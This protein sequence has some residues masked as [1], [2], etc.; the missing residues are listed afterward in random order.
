M[1]VVS[2][3]SWDWLVLERSRPTATS[4]RMA[5]TG[6]A[7]RARTARTMGSSIYGELPALDHREMSRTSLPN[8]TDRCTD[9][10]AEFPKMPGKVRRDLSQGAG[11]P[12]QV[13]RNF[14]KA[15][16]SVTNDV[17][18]TASIS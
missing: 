10:H 14:G 1:R 15:A 12:Q 6:P 3:W 18:H 9:V 4:A 16:C 5:R 8:Q 17:N 11:F 7:S 13:Q 2:S